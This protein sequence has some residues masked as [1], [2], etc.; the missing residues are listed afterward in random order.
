MYLKK[1]NVFDKFK[2]MV[3]YEAHVNLNLV[4]CFGHNPNMI[5]CPKEV[6][7]SLKVMPIKRNDY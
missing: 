1:N 7:F 6:N 4:V 5:K 2:A 3:K